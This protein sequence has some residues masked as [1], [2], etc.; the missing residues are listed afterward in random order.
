M[1]DAVDNDD[2]LL[3]VLAHEIGHV[4]G[5]HAMRLVLQNSGIAVLMTALAGDA[6]G[7]TFLAVAL[8]SM[9]VQSGYSRQF[10]AEAD[11]YAFAHLKRH[12]VSPQAFANVMRRL[13][14]ETGGAKDDGPVMR[15]LGTHPSSAERIRRAEEAR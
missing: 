5:R 14:K 4:R 11:D 13:E 6:V 12:G 10:E 3:A 7:V 15:Y 1:V 9:L 2:E 8:P